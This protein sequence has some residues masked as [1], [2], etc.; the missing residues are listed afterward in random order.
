MVASEANPL[1]KT[2]G[3]ADVVYALSKE[4]T[5]EG[6]EVTVVMPFYQAI[7]AKAQYKI[8]SIGTFDVYMS[9]R[10]QTAELFRTYID[11]I[12][13]YLIGNP[14]YFN[15]DNYYGYFDDIE[16]FAFFTLAVRNM[17]KF[18]KLK[19]DLVHIHDWQAGMLPVLIKEQNRGERFFQDMKFVT[20]IHNPAYQG[21]FEPYLLGD[22]Y[23]LSEDLF[24][25]GQVRFKGTVSSLKSAIVYS[26]KTTTVSPTHAQEL[27]SEVGSHGLNFVIQ[28][29]SD[30]FVGILNGIDYEE[31]NPAKDTNLSSNYDLHDYID[32]KSQNKAALLKEFK[33]QDNGQPVFSLVSRLTWQKGIDLIIS[34]AAFILSKGASLIILGS[35]DS[36]YEDAFNALRERFPRQVGLFVGYNEG[37]AHR[38]YSGSDFFL[39]PSLF[40]PCGISQMISLRYGTLPIVRLTGGLIDT[41]TPFTGKNLQVANGYGFYEYTANALI[42]TI[43]WALTNFS[44]KVVHS[45]LIDNAMSSLNDWTKSAKTYLALYESIES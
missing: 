43:S 29:A 7:T 19:P 22:F 42:D 36:S 17:M 34:S 8:K 14:Y 31:W 2:G 1:A 26:D 9:W 24:K 10:K 21:L 45:Q 4:L 16:R 39:M 35:G 32:G 27:L 44:N 11:G 37:L 3:L 28:Y 13:Y 5:I 33:L 15:R 38:I 30:D 23:S 41:V 25:N 18:L 6:Q 40:E 12:T 20:T